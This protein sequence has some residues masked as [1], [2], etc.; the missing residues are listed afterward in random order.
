MENLPEGMAPDRDNLVYFDTEKCQFYL[1]KWEDVG[2]RDEPLRYYLP[3]EV[4]P[5]PLF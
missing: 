2:N 1:I 5:K 4:L 3:L